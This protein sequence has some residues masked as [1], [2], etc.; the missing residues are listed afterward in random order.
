MRPLLHP[1]ADA[2]TLQALL[3]ALADPVRLALFRRLAGNAVTSVSCIKCAPVE[4]PKSSL[5]RHV[6]ILREAGLVR[7]ER[8][9]K[10]VVNRARVDEVEARFPGL[11]AAVLAAPTSSPDGAAILADR[12]EPRASGESAA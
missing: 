8:K 11:L 9:G 10:E 1:P 3:Y 12:T 4:M 6:R 7:S 2:I 5:S